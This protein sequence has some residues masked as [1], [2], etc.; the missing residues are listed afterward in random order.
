MPYHPNLPSPDQRTIMDFVK[1]LT[2]SS[3]SNQ[4]SNTNTT[5]QETSTQSNNGGFLSGISNKLNAAAGGGP[6]SEKNEDGLDKG[7]SLPF[8]SLHPVII[9]PDYSHSLKPSLQTAMSKQN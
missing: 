4:T 1:N 7:E 8:A 3:E 5:A 6:E 9:L 2:G